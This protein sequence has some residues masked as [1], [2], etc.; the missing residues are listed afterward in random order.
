M[1]DLL[2]F[3]REE[4][5][6]VAIMVL[7]LQNIDLLGITRFKFLGFGYTWDISQDME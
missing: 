6:F 7:Q 3:D 4:Q 5:D 1:E 2:D